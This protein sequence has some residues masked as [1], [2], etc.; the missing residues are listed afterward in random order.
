MFFRAKCPLDTHEKTWAEFRMQFLA[1]KLGMDRLTSGPVVLPTEEFFPGTFRETIEEVEQFGETIGNRLGLCSR[2]KFETG[3]PQLVGVPARL[4]R[5]ESTILISENE[6]HEPV[7]LVSVMTHELARH[8]LLEEGIMSGDEPDFESV[9]D[10]V[11][12]FCGMG[13]FSANATSQELT[14]EQLPRGGYLSSRLLGYALAL[15][16]WA[17]EDTQ[18]AWATYLRDDAGEVLMKSLKYLAKSNDSVFEPTAP[19]DQREWSVA[20][21]LEKVTAN[22]A[23]QRLAA[24]WYFKRHGD[25]SRPVSESIQG[26][27]RDS[28]V[29]VRRAA[30]ALI[31]KIEAPNENLQDD[32]LDAVRDSDPN[33][34][35]H[36]AMAIGEKGF[37]GP[38]IELGL[39]PLLNDTNKSVLVSTATTMARLGVKDPAV[40]EKLGKRFKTALVECNYD[41]A[42]MLAEPI[43]VMYG[44]INDF[45]RSYFAHDP[46]LMER[47]QNCLAEMREANE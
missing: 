39:Q 20:Q 7:H 19:P 18:P 8:L 21:S 29:A 47:A 10:I 41:Y 33:V 23:S 17:R 45:A 25:F 44:N 31:A 24:L 11:P 9:V 27:L 36:A 34:R 43:E 16:S 42:L 14:S 1:N 26:C 6:L 38:D 46:E 2:P 32:L 28:D 4:V 12:V 30:V 5:D 15:F 22:S 35:A 3:D 40:I 37:H 13:A